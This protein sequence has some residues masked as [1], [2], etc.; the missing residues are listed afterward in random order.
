MSYSR[1]SEILSVVRAP[2]LHNLVYLMLIYC[3]DDFDIWGCLLFCISSVPLKYHILRIGFLWP[4]QAADAGSS[5]ACLRLVVL[6]FL[7]YI[8]M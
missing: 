3:S 1:D 4:E 8:H 2:L 7:C 5:A 6:F